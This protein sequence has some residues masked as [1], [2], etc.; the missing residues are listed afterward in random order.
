MEITLGDLRHIKLALPKKKYE[1][2]IVG[3]RLELQD[4]LRRC[5]VEQKRKLLLIKTGLMQ[6]LLTGRVSVTRLMAKEESGV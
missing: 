4:R 3:E 2:S 6:D 5:L 1:Q